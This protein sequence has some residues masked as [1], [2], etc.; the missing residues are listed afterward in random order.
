MIPFSI[1]SSPK[2]SQPL[3][4]LEF[5]AEC[6]IISIKNLVHIK[7]STQIDFALQEP[8][9]SEDCPSGALPFTKNKG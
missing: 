9:P 6:I 7:N 1:I 5:T 4:I 3:L 8:C 2:Q